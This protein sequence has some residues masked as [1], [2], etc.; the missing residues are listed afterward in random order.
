MG[1][2]RLS[3]L[4]LVGKICSDKSICKNVVVMIMRRVWFT[5]EQIKIEQLGRNVFL[6]SFKNEHDRNIVWRR[7]P[8]TVN[9]AHLLHREW[10][11]DLNLAEIDF[12]LSFFWV[13]IHGLPMRFMTK[14]NAMKIGGLFAK[15]L[16]C[17]SATRTNIVGLRYIR[18]QVELDV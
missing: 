18:M 8:W 16:Q 7:Q 6:F 17:E 2:R 11:P 4:S 14:E 1:A 10:N 12:S 5:E 3:N 9:G 15:V 13:Q